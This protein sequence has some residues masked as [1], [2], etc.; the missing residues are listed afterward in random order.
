VTYENIIEHI[1]DRPIEDEVEGLESIII[2]GKSVAKGF[3]FDQLKG[4]PTSM[5]GAT[6]TKGVQEVMSRLRAD[7]LK[8]MSR[9]N[10][11]SNGQLLHAKSYIPESTSFRTVR[12]VS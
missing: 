3:G 1:I 6:S 2:P 4:T 11:P 9:A 7:T 5:F 8:S 10:T 12:S